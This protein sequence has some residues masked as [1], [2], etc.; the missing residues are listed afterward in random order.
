[1]GR[2]AGTGAALLAVLAL[3]GC[4]SPGFS[5]TEIGWRNSVLVVGSGPGLQQV[6]DV[7]VCVGDVCSTASDVA[8]DDEMQPNGPGCGEQADT[9]EV[10]VVFSLERAQ[11]S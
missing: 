5:C 9:A 1:M 4:T 2:R 6:A 8:G 10:Q 11:R 7:T 3:S